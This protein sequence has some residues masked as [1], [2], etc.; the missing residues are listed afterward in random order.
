MV[1]TKIAPCHFI[2]SDTLLQ[3]EVHG[4]SPQYQ[5]GMDKKKNSILHMTMSDFCCEKSL[6]QKETETPLAGGHNHTSHHI[7][8]SN[9]II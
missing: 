3:S 7:Y 2:A 9:P 4:E 8:T 5:M 6:G 1:D